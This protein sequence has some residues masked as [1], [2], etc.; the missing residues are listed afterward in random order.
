MLSV[1]QWVEMASRASARIRVGQQ[2]RVVIPAELR[3]ALAIQ[4]GDVLVARSE[5]D[6]LV[7]ERPRAVLERIRE[8]FRA[9]VPRG[10]SLADELIAERR[11]EARREAEET[12]SYLRGV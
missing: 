9:A 7:L 11:E 3:Q 12:E 8:R 4:P 2:G 10:I 6:K 1:A 5:Q